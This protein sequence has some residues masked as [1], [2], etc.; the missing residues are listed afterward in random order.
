MDDLCR[1]RYS[2]RGG[3]RKREKRKDGQCEREGIGMCSRLVLSLAVRDAVVG[4]ALI[5]EE[6]K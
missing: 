6:N 5:R 1:G 4:L 2:E 3:E